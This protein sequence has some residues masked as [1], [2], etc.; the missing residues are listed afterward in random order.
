MLDMIKQ[1]RWMMAAVVVL[2]IMNLALIAIMI[3]GRPPHKPDGEQTRNLEHF[4]EMELSLDQDQV[5]RV[6]EARHVHM[7]SI[8]P[9]LGDLGEVKGAI[10]VESFQ[11]NGDYLIVQMLLDQAAALH[12]DLEQAYNEYLTELAGICTPEQQARL[13]DL[14]EKINKQQALPPG[15]AGGPDSVPPDEGAFGDRPPPPDGQG[16]DRRTPPGKRARPGGPPPRDR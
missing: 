8:R 7:E 15:P 11:G 4:L 9:L 2:V 10:M 1:R 13:Q 14:V 16:K 3:V 12:R 6:R 5:Q